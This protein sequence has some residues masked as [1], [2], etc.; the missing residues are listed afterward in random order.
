MLPLTHIF[1]IWPSVV[2]QADGQPS[3]NI[4][5]IWYL[6]KDDSVGFHSHP[7]PTSPHPSLLSNQVM[8]DGLIKA[9]DEKL[10]SL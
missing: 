1:F 6:L 9:I 2:L 5:L 10:S 3:N 8:L 7:I 4:S